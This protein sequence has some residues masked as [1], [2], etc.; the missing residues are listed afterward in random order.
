MTY[1]ILGVTALAQAFAPNLDWLI[2]IRFMLGIGV[3]A[4]YVLSPVI[5][6]E[7][8]NRADRGIAI[9]LGFGTMWPL[10]A[11]AAGLFNLVL[12]AAGVGSDL[13]WRLC[14]PPAPFPRF[15]FYICAGACRKPRDTSRELRETDSRRRR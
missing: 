2:A 11:L 1:L 6:A 10:G 7:H 8:A 12:Q 3:G 9:G 5:M 14:S 4:D 13:Q 15:Q